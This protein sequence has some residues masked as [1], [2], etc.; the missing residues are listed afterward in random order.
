MQCVILAGGLG[1]RMKPRTD[2]CPKTLLEVNDHPFAWYQVQYLIK[3]EIN[4]IVYCIG[5]MGDVIRE[6]WQ[7]RLPAGVSMRYVD[8]GEELRGTGGA[9]RLAFDEGVLEEEFLVIYGDSYLPVAYGPVMEILRAGEKLAVMTVLR[10]E[11]R[12]DKSNVIFEDGTLL[13]Y[14]KRP[15]SEVI[16]YMKFIDYGLAALRSSAVAERIPPGVAY[17]LADFYQSLSAEGQLKGYEVSERFYE[18]GSPAGLSDFTSYLL[19]N[20]Y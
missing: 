10:N 9:I 2:L 17:D 13:K 8:E 7:D 14:D 15:S 12:W 1:T 5:H 20:P 6:Y 18:I 16:A 3:Q 11:G 4:N 19:K